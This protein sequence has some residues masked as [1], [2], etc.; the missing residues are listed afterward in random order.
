MVLHG[1]GVV[2]GWV[3]FWY[4]AVWFAYACAL[5]AVCFW[6]GLARVIG[7]VLVWHCDGT[8]RVW[9]WYDVGMVIA[10]F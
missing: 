1:F 4:V 10:R 9:L 5:V 3:W 7:V 6:C 8:V 2:L